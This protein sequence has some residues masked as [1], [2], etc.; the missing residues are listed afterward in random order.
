MAIVQ[1]F[2]GLKTWRRAQIKKIEKQMALGDGETDDI[3]CHHLPHCGDWTPRLWQQMVPRTATPAGLSRKPQAAK[4]SAPDPT[5][6]KH[7]VHHTVRQTSLHFLHLN[8]NP[9][10]SIYIE[11]NNEAIGKPD[12]DGLG[13]LNINK[14]LLCYF[15]ETCVIIHEYTSKYTWVIH[16]L[17]DFPTWYKMGLFLAR[18]IIPSQCPKFF[19]RERSEKLAAALSEV[20]RTWKAKLRQNK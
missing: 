7:S 2:N 13:C 8:T 11:H 14:C 16:Q 15:L 17:G 19:S 5:G 12:L 10:Q 9:W 6:T 20:R 1:G 3:S 4:T 18:V